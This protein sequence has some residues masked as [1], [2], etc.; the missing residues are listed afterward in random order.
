MKFAEDAI[1]RSFEQAS[2]AVVCE[3]HKSEIVCDGKCGKAGRISIVLRPRRRGVSSRI[4]SHRIVMLARQG[5]WPV[6]RVA[7]PDP[8]VALNA[9]YPV[10]TLRPLAPG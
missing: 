1:R 2:S 5:P 9:L 10:G 3:R 4:A 7:D 8:G 6:L